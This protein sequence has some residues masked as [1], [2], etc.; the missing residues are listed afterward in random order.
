MMTLNVHFKSQK[1]KVLLIM[2][3]YATH[4]PKHVGRGESFGFSTLQ[5]SNI[6]IVFIPPN[7]TSV[8][9]PLD[10]GITAPSIQYK[11][12]MGSH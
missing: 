6:F 12:G 9:Q 11:L 2:H 5:L 10:H 4:S 7:V 3:N 8:I 1:W